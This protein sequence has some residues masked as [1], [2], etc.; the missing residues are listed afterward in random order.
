MSK[1]NAGWIQEEAKRFIL[2]SENTLKNQTDDPA[3][4]TPLIGYS[5][6]ADPLY[7]FFQQ[8]IG[9]FYVKPIDFMKKEYPSKEFKAERL[10]IVSWI[11]PHT[12]ATKIDH[13]KEKYWPSERWARARIFG[14]QVNVKL[15]MFLVKKLKDEG[16]EAVAP[17]L[18]PLWHEAKSEKYGFASTWSERHA[19]YAAGLGTFGLSDGLITPIGKAHRAGSIIVNTFIEP[20]TRDYENHHAYCLFYAKGTC[21]ECI[22]KCPAG[23]I[24]ERGHDKLKCSEYLD[25]TRKYVEENFRFKG[26]GCGFCQVGVPCEN[27]IPEGIDD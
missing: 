8:D 9:E 2:S 10:T 1:I 20:S 25:K 18:S 17:M 16:I 23:A 15:R 13:R 3:W 26:Y 12:T 6:G 22:K 11:L 5:N 24:S 14:E 21:G 7:D 19:A 27:G 4:G